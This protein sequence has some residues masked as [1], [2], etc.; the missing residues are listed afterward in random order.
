MITLV[1]EIKLRNRPVNF[2]IVIIENTTTLYISD[3]C[4]ECNWKIDMGKNEVVKW[5][6]ELGD[7][8]SLSVANDNNL[9]VLRNL[10]GLLHLE[11]YDQDATHARRV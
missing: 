10:Q 2:N 9:L 5:L 1:D 8:I 7:E 11:L 3:R 6:S 4:P